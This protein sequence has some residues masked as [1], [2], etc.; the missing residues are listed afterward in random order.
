M[1]CMHVDPDLLV[2]GGGSAG[3]KAAI[4]ARV[5]APEVAVTRLE[6]GGDRSADGDSN[7]TVSRF[8]TSYTKIR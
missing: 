1:I 5:H 4:A 7:Q 8:S 2:I 6:K 3:F